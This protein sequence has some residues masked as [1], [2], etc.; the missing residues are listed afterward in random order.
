MKV[1]K[2]DKS[3]TETYK[4]KTLPIAELN[5]KPFLNVREASQLI[6]CSRQ[7]VYYLINTGNLKAKNILKKKT[8]IKRSEIDKLLQ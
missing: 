2:I 4:T 3:N 6:G 7:T 5:A 8:I 1:K